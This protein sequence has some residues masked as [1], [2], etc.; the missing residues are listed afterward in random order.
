MP[1]RAALPWVGQDRAFISLPLSCFALQA[2]GLATEAED[3]L[4]AKFDA[5]FERMAARLSCGALSSRQTIGASASVI[6]PHDTSVGTEP[7]DEGAVSLLLGQYSEM[8][9]QRVA[10]KLKSSGLGIV[11]QPR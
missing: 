5:L 7:R 1:A 8:L 9:V 3:A 11:R 10:Q 6:Q 2:S 4:A